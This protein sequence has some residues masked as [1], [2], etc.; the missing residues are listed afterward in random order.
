[1]KKPVI[2]GIIAALIVIVGG[3]LLFKPKNNNTTQQTATT[4]AASEQSTDNSGQG[5]AEDKNTAAT[6]TYTD[7]GFSPATLTVKADTKVTVK[8]DSSG[9]LQFSSDPHPV[10]T[11]DPELNESVIG[12]GQTTTFTVKETGTHGY[13]NHLKD[14]DTGTLIVQ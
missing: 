9:D 8:N 13:H 7:S 14:A 12:P 4:P 6:I 5:N 2:F 10:H 1:M 11:D 3:F